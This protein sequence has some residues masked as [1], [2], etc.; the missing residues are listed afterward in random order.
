MAE[1]QQFE[2]LNVAT[3]PTTNVADFK[4][5]YANNVNIGLSP[6]DIQMTFG[7]ITSANTIEHH[8]LVV[9]SPQWAKALSSV[10]QKV[11]HDYEA[12]FGQVNIP[13]QIL[14]PQ[15]AAKQQVAK[16]ELKKS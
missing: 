2:V 6:W 16:P 11:V 7:R 12:K 10:L 13:D 14:I 9:I 5:I 1:D 8:V 15:L 3:V 4:T